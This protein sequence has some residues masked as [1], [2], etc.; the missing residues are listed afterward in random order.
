M[1]RE[2]PEFEVGINPISY[3][4]TKLVETPREVIDAAKEATAMIWNHHIGKPTVMRLVF[5]SKLVKTESF[6]RRFLR[7]TQD[8]GLKAAYS[9]NTDTIQF[10]LTTI[11]DRERVK[12]PLSD[13]D[14][15]FIFAAHE[16]MHKVQFARGDTLQIHEELTDLYDTDSHEEEAWIE[17]LQAF[18]KKYPYARGG[19]QSGDR[20]FYIPEMS[21]Y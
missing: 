1:R 14:K 4:I 15:V 12:V 19:W 9:H 13:A 11:T 6:P 8:K 5:A 16:A 10:S 17:A 7:R 2:C 18:K 21:K 20:T 3:E